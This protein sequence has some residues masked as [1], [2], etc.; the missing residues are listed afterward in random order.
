ADMLTIRNFVLKLGS[1]PL[2]MSGTVNSKATPAV[3]DLN[4]KANNVSIAEAAKL[5]A[6]SGVAL[7]Q[8]TNVTGNVNANIQARGAADKP[9]LNGTVQGRNIQM[10]GKDA[11]QPVQIPAVNLTL[12]PAEIHSDNFNITSGGTNAAAQFVLKQY[13]SKNPMEIGRAHV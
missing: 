10:S 7:S 13:L 4:I 11:P 8:G 6:A 12:T 3:L 5:A 1:T 9:A 2:Q